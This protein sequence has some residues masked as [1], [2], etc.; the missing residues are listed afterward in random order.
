MSRC[1]SNT[2]GAFG[3][4]SMSIERE[5]TRYAPIVLSGGARKNQ[6]GRRVGAIILRVAAES[7]IGRDVL[8]YTQV[9]ST[10]T[11]AREFAE[12]GKAEGLVIAADEQTA[13]AG[14]WA[15]NGSSRPALRFNFRC[16][17]VRPLAPQHAARIGAHG[18]AR[19]STHAG[20]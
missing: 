9:D 16:C 15:G 18:C 2:F 8:R 17:S 4:R 1:E 6:F 3:L 19:R 13:D 14:A 20:K 11:L 7:I 5:A 10:N 12:R